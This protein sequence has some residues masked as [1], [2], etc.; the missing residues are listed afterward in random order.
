M[1][2]LHQHERQRGD[3]QSHSR[4][5]QADERVGLTCVEVEFGETYRSESRQDEGQNRKCVEVVNP[6]VDVGLAHKPCQDK[7]RRHTEGDD[8]GQGVELT[9]NRRFRVKQTSGKAVEEV[10]DGGDKNHRCSP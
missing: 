3:E 9:A 1:S 7:R 2:Y 10:E 8:V 4:Y 6:P 5:R